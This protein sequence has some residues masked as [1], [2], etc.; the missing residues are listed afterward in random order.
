MADIVLCATSPLGGRQVT[1]AGCDLR[2]VDNVALTSLAVPLGN[3][4]AFAKTLKDKLGLARPESRISTTS[5]TARA[6]SLTPDQVLVLHDPALTIDVTSQAYTTDQTGNWCIL[7]LSGPNARDALSRICPLDLDP[8]AFPVD[9]SA[10]TVMEHLGAIIICIGKDSYLL[11]S[12]SSSAESF[13]HAVE[14]S[15][16]N[17]A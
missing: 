16:H 9:A 13:W 6:L 5:K 11:L 8:S 17:V 14:V 7:E 4:K 15:L 2:E 10:R 1:L 12:A 3:D